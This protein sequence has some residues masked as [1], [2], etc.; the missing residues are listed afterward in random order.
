M[1]ERKSISKIN[2]EDNQLSKQLKHIRMFT[3][4]EALFYNTECKLIFMD[5]VRMNRNCS[6]VYKRVI[7]AIA[8]EKLVQELCSASE[9][10]QKHALLLI[11]RYFNN[12]KTGVE[13]ENSEFVEILNRIFQKSLEKSDQ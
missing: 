13:L 7:D 12:I 10:T 8:E 3:R 6:L 2:G 4:M 1:A 9:R 5:E 11:E